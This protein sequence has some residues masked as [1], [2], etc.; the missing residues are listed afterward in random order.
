V[1]S[2]LKRRKTVNWKKLSPFWIMSV[3]SSTFSF[4]G[5]KD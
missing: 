4:H 5:K 1:S 2:F 3:L